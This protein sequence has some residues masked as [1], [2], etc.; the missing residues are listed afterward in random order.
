MNEKIAI[1]ASSINPVKQ[2]HL[3]EWFDDL[4]SR[5]VECKLFIG[6]KTAAI[7]HA[8]NYKINSKRELLTYFLKGKKAHKNQPLIDYKAQIIHLLTSNTFDSIEKA[9]NKNT[10][11]IVSYRGYDLNV[12][13]HTSDAHLKK[14]QALFKRANIL[15][16]NS[17]SLMQ[18]AID[19]GANKKKC[20]VIYRSVRVKP[21]LKLDKVKTDSSL[22][23]LSVGRLVWEKGY[24]YGLEALSLVKNKGFKFQYCIAGDGIDENLIRFH[25]ERLNLKRQVQLLGLLPKKDIFKL[26]SESDVFF[27]TSLIESLPNSV[28][29]ASL[30]GL[31]VVSSNAGGI[32]EVI[33]HEVSGL[34]SEIGNAEKFA[35]NLIIVLESKDLREYMGKKGREIIDKKFSSENEIKNWLNL[36]KT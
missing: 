23:I 20:V 35:S 11:L 17:K 27:Q 13:P 12:F 36:Y 34:L 2:A 21:V 5:G 7:P 18:T 33:E 15:H 6:S 22:K 3:L 16:F 10:I 1:I 24:T 31:P 26:M 29:E 19:L 9:I 14:T 4:S 25:I 28:I 32:S 8:L 30:A